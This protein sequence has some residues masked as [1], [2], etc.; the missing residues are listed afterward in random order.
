M[1]NFIAKSRARLVFLKGDL[2]VD[3][4]TLKHLKTGVNTDD[5]L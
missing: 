4:D 3:S 2:A 5:V 1:G